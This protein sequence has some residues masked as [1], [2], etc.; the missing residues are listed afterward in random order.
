MLAVESGPTRAMA[1]V[2]AY[3]TSPMTFPGPTVG[4]ASGTGSI[5]SKRARGHVVRSA[6]AVPSTSATPM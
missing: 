2:V 4:R 1:T 5:G 6:A 3:R